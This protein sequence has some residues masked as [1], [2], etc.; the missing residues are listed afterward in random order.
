MHGWMPCPVCRGRVGW[1]ERIGVRGAALQTIRLKAQRAADAQRAVDA[2]ADAA[3]AAAASGAEA[4]DAAHASTRVMRETMAAAV[5]STAAAEFIARALVGLADAAG[6]P[7]R[8]AL[9]LD[10]TRLPHRLVVP[11]LARVAAPSGQ[12]YVRIASALHRV[13]I[14]VPGVA[15]LMQE[16]QPAAAAAQ[17][18]GGPS[19]GAHAEE[20]PPEVDALVHALVQFGALR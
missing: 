4:A 2:R 13:R 14:A 9:P 5:G 12:G 8:A 19:G 16:G 7:L 17:R 20:W 10:Q 18:R 3:A 6:R 11:L 1:I 15:D